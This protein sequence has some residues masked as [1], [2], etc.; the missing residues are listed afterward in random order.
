MLEEIDILDCKRWPSS[1]ESP[2][3]EGERR[4]K[5]LCCRLGTSFMESREAFR[6][7]IDD[8]IIMPAELSRLKTVIDTLPVTSAD[9]ERGFST[10]NVICTD[11]RNSLTVSHID[12]LM[13]ISLVG[14]PVRQFKPGPYVRI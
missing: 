12:N 8:P 2:W 9:C 14:P 5:S 7:Y 4:L 3:L 1:I 10:M 11:L 13:V 6:D